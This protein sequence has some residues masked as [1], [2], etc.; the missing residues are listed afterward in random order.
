M[1]GL[2]TLK[3]QTLHGDNEVC[4]LKEPRIV[5]LP[6]HRRGQRHN[7]Q[8]K[9]HSVQPPEVKYVQ[10]SLEED[11]D[12]IEESGDWCTDLKFTP[13]LIWKPGQKQHQALPLTRRQ[14]ASKS[15]ISNIPR[16]VTKEETPSRSGS[17]KNAKTTSHTE[18]ERTFTLTESTKTQ[19]FV[20]KT[21]LTDMLPP[22]SNHPRQKVRLK[23]RYS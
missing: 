18:Q 14:Q 9:P 7:I 4:E 16:P 17:G 22:L 15:S 8:S 19:L 23:N 10:V 12:S 21:N 2:P 3:I 11:D 6:S 13:V 1:D 20:R 5:P